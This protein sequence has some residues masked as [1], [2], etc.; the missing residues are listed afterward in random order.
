MTADGVG[1]ARRAARKLAVEAKKRANSAARLYGEHPMPARAVTG[2]EYADDVEP[3][4]AALTPGE[5]GKEA[6]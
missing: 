4:S 1:E 2:A 3:L 5:A 6:P